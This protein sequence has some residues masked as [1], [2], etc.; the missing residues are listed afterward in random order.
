MA[1]GLSPESLARRS[2]RRPWTTI[3]LWGLAMLIALGLIAG[4]GVAA[5]LINIEA[6]TALLPT[7]MPFEP[8]GEHFSLLRCHSK[9]Q[10]TFL[11]RANICHH[12]H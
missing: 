8:A 6:L 1:F 9:N 12:P 11:I 10:K 5:G 3:G 2:A 7:P 4:L